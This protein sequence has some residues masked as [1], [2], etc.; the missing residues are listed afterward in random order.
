MKLAWICIIFGTH[1]AYLYVSRVAFGFSTGGLY[2]LI[3]LFI[4][5]ISDERLLDNLSLKSA[6]VDINLKTVF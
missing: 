6:A 2:T 3:P 4:T 1:I 5:E